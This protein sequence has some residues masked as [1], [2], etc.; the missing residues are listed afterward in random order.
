MQNNLKMADAYTTIVYVRIYVHTILWR[1][2]K[3]WICYKKT[4][5]LWSE[6]VNSWR[7]NKKQ[8]KR[9]KK[10]NDRLPGLIQCPEKKVKKW[11]Q[12][13][14]TDFFVWFNYQQSDWTS[15]RWHIF[16]GSFGVVVNGWEDLK[17]LN[18]NSIFLND[19]TNWWFVL[20]RFKKWVDAN[21]FPHHSFFILFQ[22]EFS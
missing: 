3:F 20:F 4:Q 14:C 18:N 10:K 22:T 21:L 11:N 19:Q 16:Y 5:N 8:M 1:I 12:Q 6:T 17:G 15:C 9:Q 13:E 2:M 7:Q